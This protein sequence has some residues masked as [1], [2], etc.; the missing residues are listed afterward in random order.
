MQNTGGTSGIEYQK[1]ET[2]DGETYKFHVFAPS[3]AF[4]L[5]ARL[6]KFLGEPAV[7]MAGVPGDNS[8]VLLRNAVNALVNNL[9]ENEVWALIGELML[10]VSYDGK[11]IS[12]DVHFMGRLGHLLKVVTKVVEFQFKDFFESIGQAI[13]AVTEKAK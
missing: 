5:G 12:V 6:A 7:A 10:S 9:N 1:L 13:T 4:K 8:G 2:V 3:K 11:P